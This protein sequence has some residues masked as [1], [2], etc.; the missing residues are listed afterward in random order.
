VLLVNASTLPLYRRRPSLVFGSKDKDQVLCSWLLYF[1]LMLK[2]GVSF[3]FRVGASVFL[4]WLFRRL[5]IGALEKGPVPS[6]FR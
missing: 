3:N 6:R 2:V 5:L 4:F 1:M